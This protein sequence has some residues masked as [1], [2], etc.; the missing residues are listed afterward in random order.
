M[1]TGIELKITVKDVTGF[2][3]EQVTLTLMDGRTAEQ[4]ADDG[5]GIEDAAPATV[6]V[7]SSKETPTVTFSTDSI[8]IDEGDSE[9]VHLLAGGM[10]GDEVGA[11]TVAVRGDADISLEQNGSPIGGTVSFGGNANAELTIVANSD[12]SLEDGEE[13]TATVSI[14]NASGALIGDPNTVTVTVVGSTA[15][16]V[17]P[18]VGQLLL[19]LLLM[20]GGARL[21]RRRQG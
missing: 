10:Q 1:G 12:P 17:L 6:T 9:T 21:Y 2:R 19:A 14:T 11:V 3:D 20:V 5:G 8:D 7:L 4:K 16:P 15:V 18:L 13:K